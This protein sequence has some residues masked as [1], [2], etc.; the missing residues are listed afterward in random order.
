LRCSDSGVT[1][2][3]RA[4]PLLY[5]ETKHRVCETKYRGCETKHRQIYLCSPAARAT[6]IYQIFSGSATT[7]NILSVLLQVT[8]YCF[9]ARPNVEVAKPKIEVAKPI[10][11]TPLLSC[12][13]KHRGCETKYRG[14]ETKPNIDTCE[15]KGRVPLNFFWEHIEVAKPNL[16]R[17]FW[18]GETRVSIFLIN[19]FENFLRLCP[20]ISYCVLANPNVEAA[21]PKNPIKSNIDNSLM[22]LCAC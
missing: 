7:N 3:A 9:L 13:T 8:R 10:I 6:F 19:L 11:D 20:Y 22:M 16:A 5:C 17:L 21:N 4:T 12:E 2:A 1:E 15:T 14:C 18:G